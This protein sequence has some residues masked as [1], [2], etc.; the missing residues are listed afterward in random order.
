MLGYSKIIIPLVTLM[1]YGSLFVNSNVVRGMY[2]LY[3]YDERSRFYFD[4]DPVL[5]RHCQN[6]TIHARLPPTID[7]DPKSF[8]KGR[9]GPFVLH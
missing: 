7:P 4:V 9:L 5:S 3:I 6:H 2:G 8:S 1:S